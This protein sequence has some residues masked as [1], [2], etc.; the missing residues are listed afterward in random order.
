MVDVIARDGDVLVVSYP[1]IKVPVVK[2]GAVG[3][4]NLSY[5]R[6]LIAGESVREQY[7]CIMALL[8][9]VAEND[10]NAKVEKWAQQLNPGVSPRP[11]PP[12][13]A[14]RAPGEKPTSRQVAR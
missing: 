7:E 13:L 1:E 2:Y 14:E 10:A 9:D 4:G 3:V 6:R 11:I 5:T 12:R 8:T